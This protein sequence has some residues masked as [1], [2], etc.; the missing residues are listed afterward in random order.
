M[1]TRIIR[2][3]RPA[4]AHGL[5][6]DP[7]RFAGRNGQHAEHPRGCLSIARD[8]HRREGIP[9]KNCETV[10][11]SWAVET[12]GRASLQCPGTTSHCYKE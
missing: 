12:H 11:V 5:F 4:G 8:G 3:V 1:K 7:G 10:T 9:T 2:P 6:A